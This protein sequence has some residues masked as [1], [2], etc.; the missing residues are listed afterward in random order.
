[1]PQFL[2]QQFLRTVQRV[3]LEVRPLFLPQLVR[4]VAML[5]PALQTLTW[6]DPTWECFCQSTAAA[7]HKFDVLV[8]RVHDVYSNRILQVLTSMQKVTLQ[9]LPDAD[10]WS[11]EE[12]LE[13]TEDTCRQA[14]AVSTRRV[15]RCC[16][17]PSPRNWRGRGRAAR[18][19]RPG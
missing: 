3:K 18:S 16:A 1:M 7:I 15:R 17:P 10:P 19:R 6:T 14:A 8:T 4:L 12:F 13:N 2:V 11:V 5:N 9:A